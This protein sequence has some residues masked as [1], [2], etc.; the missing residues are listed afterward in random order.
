MAVEKI[1]HP[2]HY[3]GDTVY[4]A[5]KV[6]EAWGLGFCLGNTIKYISR[7]GKKEDRLEDLQKAKW[8]LDREILEHVSKKQ[9][10]TCC[11]CGQ[12]LPPKE[13]V[14]PKMRQRIFR[15]CKAARR[16]RGASVGEI[17]DHV[18]ADDSERRPRKRQRVC[19]RTQIYF[20][21]SK[22]RCPLGLP[23]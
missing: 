5:I 6:I 18:H 17:A 3:G 7:A 23:K 12:V 19:I 14:L 9:V 16:R 10:A 4:E 1:N 2:A 11:C 15:L 22:V 8:Y 13:I 20:I 21:N